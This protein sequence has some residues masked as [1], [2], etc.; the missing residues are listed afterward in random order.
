MTLCDKSKLPIDNEWR[1]A[2]TGVL[3]ILPQLTPEEEA[4]FKRMEKKRS[5]SVKYDKLKH[6]AYLYKFGL[7]DP[8]EVG[9]DFPLCQSKR[10]QFH[11]VRTLTSTGPTSKDTLE[12]IPNVEIADLPL[13]TEGVEGTVPPQENIPPSSTPVTIGSSE[14]AYITISI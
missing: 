3:N 12:A 14:S 9:E 6:D 1:F 10:K 4:T 8:K 5:P 13:W 11:Q 7:V 2:E